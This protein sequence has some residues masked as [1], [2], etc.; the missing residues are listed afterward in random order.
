MYKFAL[1][2]LVILGTALANNESKAPKLIK[3]A[4]IDSGFDF[5]SKWNEK[6]GLSDNGY[7]KTVRM[8]KLCKKGHEDFTK[9]GKP[10]EITDSH[11]HGTHVAGVIAQYAE[12]SNYCLVIL[13]YYHPK[14]S[15]KENLKNS[16]KALKKAKSLNVNIINYSGGGSVFSIEEY[17][18][19]QSILDNGITLVAAAGND[20]LK[21]N[22]DVNQVVSG[23]LNDNP[24]FFDYSKNTH[25]FLKPTYVYYP[26][27]IDTRV[28]AVQ[29]IDKKGKLLPTSNRGMTYKYK[30]VGKN[31][32]SI[33]PNNRLGKMTGT[34]QATAVKT[35]KLI[36]AWKK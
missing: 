24:F 18:V 10:K 20:Y 2:T 15:G 27:A 13:K 14:A 7:G 29:S 35:G 34:S 26:A 17:G 4:V 36:R 21:E 11:G 12:N 3:V 32:I 25:V 28:I 19:V 30:E 9:Y 1:V 31:L 8:P 5:K 23:T 33:L 16:I 22:I 6:I